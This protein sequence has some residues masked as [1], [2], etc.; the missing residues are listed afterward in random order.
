MA[1]LGTFVSG[2]VLTAAELNAIGTWENFPAATGFTG[3]TEGNGTLIQRYCVLNDVVLFEA[4]FEL[5]STSALTDA[6]FTFPVAATEADS[7]MHFSAGI[8][9]GGT[10]Y[11]AIVRRVDT[12]SCVIRCL[13]TGGT[14]VSQQVIS[15]TVPFTWGTADAIAISGF[16]DKG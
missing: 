1:T 6:G 14:Y 7:A 3:I 8:A 4:T 11:A 2:Q 9:D 13:G 12:T 10:A 15:S 5:G 16:Y